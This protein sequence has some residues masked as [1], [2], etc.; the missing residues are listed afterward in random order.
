MSTWDIAKLA[1]KERGEHFLPHRVASQ[2]HAFFNHSDVKNFIKSN[3]FCA[4]WDTRLK[5]HVGCRGEPHPC[6][7]VIQHNLHVVITFNPYHEKQEFSSDNNVAL[8]AHCPPLKVQGRS[9][10]ITHVYKA[11]VFIVMTTG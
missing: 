10:A 5:A 9:A 1:F 6:L 11:T 7:H 4:N 3:H 8:Y 2:G